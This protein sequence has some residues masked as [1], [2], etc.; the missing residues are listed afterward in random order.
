MVRLLKCYGKECE[1]QGKKYPKEELYEHNGK[2]YC[3]EHLQ[4]RQH[5]ERDRAKLNTVIK[6]VFHIPYP[7]M[8]MKAQ[9]K[10][11]QQEYSYNLNDIADTI[12]YMSSLSRVII[13][14][15]KGLGLVPYIYD[16]AMAER[17]RKQQAQ[18]VAV[19]KPAIKK[20]V[21][22]VSEDKFKTNDLASKNKKFDFGE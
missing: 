15:S 6:Q 11:F 8:R 22:T 16:E 10:R 20:R 7:S 17:L 1:E 9:I 18:A 19:E 4:A 21:I 13:D 2:N 3:F 5:E 12:D 14:E